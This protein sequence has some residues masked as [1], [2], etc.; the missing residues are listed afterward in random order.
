MLSSDVKK[1]AFGGTIFD[2]SYAGA[3]FS[4]KRD[5]SNFDIQSIDTGSP[6]LLITSDSNCQIIGSFKWEDSTWYVLSGKLQETNG[7][8]T[9][10][11]HIFALSDLY[12]ELRGGKSPLCLLPQG[13]T[14]L[15]KSLFSRK[16]GGLVW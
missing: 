13:I 4:F 9:I 5:M 7:S 3:K 14:A 6:N 2:R 16:R 15:I 8:T 10:A 12:V 1:I 11:D